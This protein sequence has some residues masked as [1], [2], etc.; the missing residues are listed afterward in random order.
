MRKDKVESIDVQ[1]PELTAFM[2]DYF[3][4]KRKRWACVR[5]YSLWQSYLA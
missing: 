1:W 5:A 4:G 2:C 3:N